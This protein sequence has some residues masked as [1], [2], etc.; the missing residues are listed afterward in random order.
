ML[1]EVR[2][3]SFFF[4][5]TIFDRTVFKQQE[6]QRAARDIA[7]TYRVNLADW[8]RAANELRQP[9]WGWDE[10]HTMVPPDQVILSDT[11][12]II[13][14]N[15]TRVFVSNPFKA[16]RFPPGSTATF[17]PP[18]NTW[19]ST[20]RHPDASGQTNVAALRAYVV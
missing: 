6:V 13:E 14:P 15:G 17:S 2:L 1:F 20:T 4:L 3:P 10:L 16:F 8:Q 12:Q 11:V 7:N 5:L 19:Q 18:F 9:Y